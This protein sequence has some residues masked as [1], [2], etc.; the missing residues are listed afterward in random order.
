MQYK[1]GTQFIDFN[2]LEQDIA[3]TVQSM[4]YSHG[5]TGYIYK[6]GITTPDDAY[7]YM[8]IREGSA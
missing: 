2:A 8:M 4:Q 5:S 7:N 6:I 1:I 3:Y